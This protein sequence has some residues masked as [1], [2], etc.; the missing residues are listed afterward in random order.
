MEWDKITNIILIASIIVLGLFAVLGLTQW[1]SRKSL[2]KV[3][4][5]LLWMILPIALMVIV[6]LVFDKVLP[7]IIKPYPLVRP[8]NS[9]E[10]SFPSTHVMIV[11]TIFFCASA[12]LPK[13]TKSKALI[14]IIDIIMF[15]LASLVA[16][17][18][19]LANKHSVVDIIGGAIFA[20]IFYEIYC[21]CL[22][23]KKAKKEE[24]PKNE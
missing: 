4:K 8:D 15:A 11:T 19:V 6:Y 20:F 7:S 24:E 14:F 22:R 12:A 5:Q 13:Y 9:G 3:D 1:I 16:T 10:P 2:K 18:R 21:A 23:K 17:G